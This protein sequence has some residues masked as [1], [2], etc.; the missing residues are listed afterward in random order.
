MPE[1]KVRLHSLDVLRGFDMFWIIGG[2][3]LMEALRGLTG[4]RLFRVLAE[5]Q[6]HAAWNGFR[7]EDLIFPLFIFIAGVTIPFSLGRDLERGVP[8]SRVHLRILRRGL[9]LVLLGLLYQGILRF[10]FASQR[11]C[12]VLGRIGLAWSLGA[13]VAVN[14]RPRRQALWIAGILLGYWAVMKLVP[15]PGYGPGVLTQEGS[16]VGFI[17]RHLCPGRLYLGNHDPEGLLSTVPAVATTLLGSLTGHYLRATRDSGPRRVGT[18]ALAGLAALAAGWLWHP[19]FPVNKNLW[20][21]S[22]VLVTAGWSL[23]LLASFHYLVDLKG[24]G[25]FFLPFMLIGL[26][27]LTIY[28]A[29]EGILDFEGCMRFFLGGVLNHLAP[30]LAA[31]VAVL[32]VLALKVLLVGFLHRQKIY[33]K[34]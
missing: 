28:I 15:V 1:T 29:Q 13:L 12:S 10:D 24:W 30:A 25:R 7:F 34:V 31:V 4:W 11:Y 19:L 2:G 17:D 22:F 26:N 14:A 18:L 27:P 33:L 9:L 3:A 21:S 23:L 20:T 32:G 5:Q 8:R 6:E 16:L